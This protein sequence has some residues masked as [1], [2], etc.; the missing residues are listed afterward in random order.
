MENKF[1]NLIELTNY[2]NIDLKCR[3]YLEQ[4]IWE[5]KPTCPHCKH[6]EKIYRF[7]DGKLFKC[8]K[9]RKKFTIISGT[10]IENSNVSLQKWLVA[11][12]LI[13]STKKGIS[14]V[15]LGKAI[16]TT[17]KSAW[18]MLCRIREMLKQ[19][20]KPM[21]NIVEVDETYI[22]GKY[23]NKHWKDRKKGGQGRS[24]VDKIVVFGML[25][26]EISYNIKRPNKND[27]TKTI[28]E[29][30]IVK[31]SNVNSLSVIDSKSSTL[32]PIIQNNVI[33][34]STIM[35]D[36]WKGYNGLKLDYNHLK[37]YHKYN[38]YVND[39]CYTNTLEGYWGLVKRN[40]VGIYHNTSAKHIN[41]YLAEFD[42]RYNNRKDS[43]VLRFNTALAGAKGRLKYKD[44]I[45]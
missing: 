35:S 26:R 34:G 33:K 20:T 29:K 40:I 5:G 15:Q 37:V 14:S 3:K 31:P 12:F 27:S 25:E 36:E 43:E 21:Q 18:F 41:R 23:K 24:G 10:V 19:E 1:K 8:S 28:I 30:I 38:Q 6:N 7:K 42:F 4:L 16:G 22:G 45:K 2:F 32:K 9:C 17:Q 39:N 11:L 13:S 44:L